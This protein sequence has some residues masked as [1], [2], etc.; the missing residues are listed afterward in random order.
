MFWQNLNTTSAAESVMVML[1]DVCVLVDGD[2][3]PKPVQWCQ[4]CQAWICA[5]C[6]PNLF[7]RSQAMVRRA[8]GHIFGR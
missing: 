8:A 7:R 4:E 6:W 3:S 2:Y 5:Q 1:C